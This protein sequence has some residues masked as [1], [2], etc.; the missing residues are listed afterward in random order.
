MITKER[1]RRGRHVCVPEAHNV[2]SKCVE[3]QP[4]ELR[5]AYLLRYAVLCCAVLFHTPWHVT[6]CYSTQRLPSLDLLL[7]LF[8]IYPMSCLSFVVIS[9]VI[10]FCSAFLFGSYFSIRRRK[11]NFFIF[12]EHNF[13][14]QFTDA[15]RSEEGRGASPCPKYV[16]HSSPLRITKLRH[17]LLD[18]LTNPCAI[19]DSQWLELMGL[20]R[21]LILLYG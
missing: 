7:V 6:L 10:Y 13:Q 9:Y 18:G 4:L 15:H 19:H 11:V 14:T 5:N 8:C 21:C 20:C 2:S 17:D 16:N 3:Q 12:H 1:D